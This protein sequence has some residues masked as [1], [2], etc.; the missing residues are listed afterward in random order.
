MEREQLKITYLYNSGFV[1]E[2]ENR[3]LI[4]DCCNAQVEGNDSTLLTG[5]VSPKDFE[6]KEHI[7]I[8]A[9]HGHKDH[10]YP[11]ILRWGKK[12]NRIDYVLSDDIKVGKNAIH[13]RG[14]ESIDV[15]G[16]SVT[17][18]KSNDA[19]VSYLVNLDGNVIFHA[20]DTN[21]WCKEPEKTD[22]DYIE[23]KY[24]YR[25]SKIAFQQAVAPIMK[26]KIDIVFF[27]LDPHIG[28]GYENGALY[29]LS[30]VK[31]KLFIPMHFGYLYDACTK[32]K[33]VN[34]IPDMT[35]WCINRQGQQLIYDKNSGEAISIENRW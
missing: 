9:S 6:G 2:T 1:V 28:L 21:L 16:M 8:F 17:A 29:F 26:R 4:F 30:R 34:N 10:F 33:K 11:L 14:N 19:G 15:S 22:T 32:F 5:T 35:V 18:F 27:P 13:I 12:N 24:R 7:T 20:G 23:A 31:P 25:L 3:M